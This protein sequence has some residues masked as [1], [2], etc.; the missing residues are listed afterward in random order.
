MCLI[1]EVVLVLVFTFAQWY[2]TN[3]QVP[4]KIY[5]L[6]FNEVEFLDA[7]RTD[8]EKTKFQLFKKRF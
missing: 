1:S 5:L 2:P 8:S 3:S 4:Q 7:N 6:C